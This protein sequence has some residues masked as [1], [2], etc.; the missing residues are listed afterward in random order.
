[1]KLTL[2]SISILLLAAMTVAGCRST[3]TASE[4]GVEQWSNVYVPVRLELLQPKRMSVSGRATMV[5][6]RSI[7]MSFRFIGLEVASAYCDADSAFVVMKH[8]Q[9]MIT[10][11]LGPLM[12]GT[13]LGIGDIQDILLGE[14]TV[15]AK[16][17]GRVTCDVGESADGTRTVTVRTVGTRQPVEARIV[18]SMPD[19]EYNLASPRQWSKPDGYT[20]VPAD[21]LIANLDKIF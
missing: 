12:A 11:A 1:M 13:G 2:K 3:K 9:T 5:R 20:R 8:N 10:S 17:A 18:W 19:A 7:Y 4:P 21:K 6:D 16:A 15:P 14:G